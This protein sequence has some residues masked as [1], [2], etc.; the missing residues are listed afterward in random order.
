MSESPFFVKVTGL[1]A[2]MRAEHLKEFA[3]DL[4]V[5]RSVFKLSICELG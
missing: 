1:K 4:A 2:S 5:Y 3:S